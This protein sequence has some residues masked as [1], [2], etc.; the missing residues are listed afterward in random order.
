LHLIAVKKTVRTH[1]EGHDTSLI[2]NY[3]H[4]GLSKAKQGRSVKSTKQVRI[5][6]LINTLEEVICDTLVTL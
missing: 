5:K 6:M 2:N 1:R 4:L 3:V